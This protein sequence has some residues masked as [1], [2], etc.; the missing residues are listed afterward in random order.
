[1]PNTKY[2]ILTKITEYQRKPYEQ[3][4]KTEKSL[5]QIEIVIRVPTSLFLGKL[6]IQSKKQEKQEEH[7]M[8]FKHGKQATAHK[9]N[10][11]YS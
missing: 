6:H 2:S 7:Q 5:P 11:L 9:K 3:W 10:K 4:P 8:K 1:M